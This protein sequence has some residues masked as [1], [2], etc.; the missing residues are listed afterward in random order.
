MTRA[1][2]AVIL[3]RVSTEEQEKG[4]SIDAQLHRLEQYCQR[5]ELEVIETYTV[6]ESSTNGERK[7]FNQMLTFVKRQRQCIA[8]VADKVDRVQRSFKEFPMLD[9]LVRDGKIELH[10][11]SEGYVIHKDSVSQDRFMWS[12][13]VVLAQGY[14]D[15]LRDNVKRSIAHKLRGG[16]W[17]S[18]APIGYLH[19]TNEKGKP[20]IKIDPV[21]APLVRQ[22]FEKYATGCYSIS[23]LVTMARDMGL[24]NSRGHKGELVKSHMHKILQETFYYG[25]MKVKRTGEE[26]PHRYETIIPKSLYDTC[27]QVRTGKG[28]PHSRY[29]GKD[30]VFRGLLTCAVTGRMCTAETSKKKYANGEFGEWTYVIAYR[31]DAPEKKIW[32]REDDVERQVIAVLEQL[33]MKDRGYFED[34]M[35]WIENTHNAKKCHHKKQTAMLKH[36]HTE[37]ETKLEGLMDLRISGELNKEEFMAMKKRLK[38]RQLEINELVHAYDVTDDEFNN[39]LCLLLNMADHAAKHYTG[40]GINEKRELLSFVFQNLTLKEKKLE[41]TMRYPF[42]LFADANKTGEWC[43]GKDSN[44]HILANTST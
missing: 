17:I 25:I 37:I 23:Q 6:V 7:Q 29:A 22:L 1:T 21:R 18:Q 16:E 10:F 34:V 14:V 35:G 41:Y 24:N 8:I 19:F 39:R 42:N 28:K 2:K 44:L 13:G 30:Y 33:S 36:E 20:D 38:D 31:E 32:V 27:Q 15:S 3:A 26:Y 4:Y 40:S 11:N 9:A 43:P 5:K 12:I